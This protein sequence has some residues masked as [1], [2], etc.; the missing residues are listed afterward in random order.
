MCSCIAL[1]NVLRPRSFSDGAHFLSEDL[2]RFSLSKLTVSSSWLEVTFFLSAL[3]CPF[4]LPYN[5]EGGGHRKITIIIED[6]VAGWQC[7]FAVLHHLTPSTQFNFFS[8]MVTFP[9]AH[10]IWSFSFVL[11]LCFSVIQGQLVSHE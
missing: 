10:Y 3:S 1:E 6:P 9:S 4:F 11:P 2:K 5:C 7:S 8:C